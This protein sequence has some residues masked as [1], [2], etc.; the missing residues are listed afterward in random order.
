MVKR[1]VS[2]SVPMVH[3]VTIP[4]LES[5]LVSSS[6]GAVAAKMPKV[7]A[8]AILLVLL[9]VVLNFP[10]QL[11]SFNVFFPVC[12]SLL[13]EMRDDFSNGCLFCYSTGNMVL[14][15][16]HNSLI[17]IGTMKCFLPFYHFDVLKGKLGLFVG[18]FLF[19]E[20]GSLFPLPKGMES[21]KEGF[22]LLIYNG[23]DDCFRE[24]FPS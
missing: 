11:V 13:F 12:I 4:C 5:L 2:K 21:G 3:H 6:E 8:L 7:V 17:H 10:A 16:L 14:Q 23:I 18:D 19:C 22:I 9:G 20:E 1:L 24:W 15:L